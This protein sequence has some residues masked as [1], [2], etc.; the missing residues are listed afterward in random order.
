MIDPSGLRQLARKNLPGILNEGPR[1]IHEV[2][3]EIS[4]RL[5]KYCDDSV[6]C[7][8]S[9]TP[10]GPEW[11]HRIRGALQDLRSKGVVAYDREHRVWRKE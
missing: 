7:D 2:Y 4:R 10:R 3:Q 1:T 8:C 11:Q 5:P 9:S 6:I